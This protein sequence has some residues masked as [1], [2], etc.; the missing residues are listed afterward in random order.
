MKF[1]LL[2]EQGQRVTV[3]QRNIN[4]ACHQSILPPAEP[5]DML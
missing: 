4:Q 2:H 5:S 1:S 3:H